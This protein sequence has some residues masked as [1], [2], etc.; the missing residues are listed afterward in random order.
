MNPLGEKRIAARGEVEVVTVMF[1]V[2]ERRL[3]ESWC[4]AMGCSVGMEE[5][6]GA[7]W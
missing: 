2:V 4:V 6:E 1:V 7:G 5:R 3:A